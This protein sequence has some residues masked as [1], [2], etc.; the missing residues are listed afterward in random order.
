MRILIDSS[1]LIDALRLRH[2]RRELLS[3][4]VRDGHSLATSAI[5]IAEIF[6]G[7]RPEEERNTEAL[8][9]LFQCH[10]ITGSAGRLAG[11][12]K[13]TW[14]RKG[15]SLTLTDMTIAAV[16]IEQGCVLM[17]DNL[18]DFPMDNLSLYSLPPRQ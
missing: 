14:G 4:L 10:E 3:Q 8:L 15:K 6:A 18:K 13:N 1:V 7:M 9:T 11:K 2:G 5:N 16:A 12:L 17:T